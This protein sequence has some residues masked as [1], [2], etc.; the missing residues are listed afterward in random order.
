VD[1][2]TYS[3]HYLLI[4]G[5]ALVASGLTFFTGFGLGTLLL[6]A[7]AVFFPVE[8]AVALTAVVHFLNSL[9]KLALVGRRADLDVAIRFGLPAIIAALAGAQVL[10]WLSDLPPLV[11]Y[12]LAGHRFEVTPVKLAMAVLMVLFAALEVFPGMKGISVPPRYLPLGGLLTGF[13]GGVSG[14]QGALRSA[15]LLRAGLSK[16]AFIATGVVIAAVVDLA[17]LGIYVEGIIAL[18]LKENTPLLAA[19]VASAFMGAIIGNRLLAKVTLQAIEL[20]VAALLV[21]VA[22]GL[23]SGVL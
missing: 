4:C 13:F 15:F 20:A 11:S 14:H 7:F 9:F 12:G 6:P 3:L 23:G 2:G 1:E 19:G 5:V 18:N 16:E 10:V 8:I 17:R 22:L 21:V